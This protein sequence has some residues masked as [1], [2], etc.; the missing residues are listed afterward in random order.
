MHAVWKVRK[1]W[2]GHGASRA[3][4]TITR[5]PGVAPPPA[6]VCRRENTGECV[7]RVNGLATVSSPR[8]L[9]LW[10]RLVVSP[11]PHMRELPPRACRSCAHASTLY[12]RASWF[13][14]FM[15]SACPPLL[16]RPQK[17][18][19]KTATPWVSR[20]REGAERA[21]A[22]ALRTETNGFGGLSQRKGCIP[23]F[24][25]CKL[26]RNWCQ[27]KVDRQSGFAES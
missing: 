21:R 27:T 19:K 16:G 6:C 2:R 1:I 4:A 25:V 22:V 17:K 15:P 26:R 24:P 10:L 8:P 18:K 7:G 20:W 11:A 23:R 12:S 9:W 14:D 13:T 3:H 5:Q